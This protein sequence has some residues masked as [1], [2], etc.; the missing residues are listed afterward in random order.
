M[1]EGEDLGPT[2]CRAVKGSMGHNIQMSPSNQGEPYNPHWEGS[3]S[4][5]NLEGL[6]LQ[7]A[8]LRGRADNNT[9]T[10]RI[11]PR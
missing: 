11:Y 5:L 3:V 1:A 6:P 7:A 2:Y 8:P 10:A 4:H 9:Y